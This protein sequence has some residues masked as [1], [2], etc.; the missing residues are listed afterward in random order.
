MRYTERDGL[1]S[2][3]ANSGV[4]TAGARTSGGRLWF[5]TQRGIA[6]VDPSEADPSP[7]A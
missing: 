7:P 4:H 2:R 5:P 3:E 1:N 6:V